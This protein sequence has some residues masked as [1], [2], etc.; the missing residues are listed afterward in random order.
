[1]LVTDEMQEWPGSCLFTCVTYCASRLIVTCSTRSTSSIV[2]G[3][4]FLA[5]LWRALRLP[6]RIE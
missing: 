1:M 5:G 3:N 2:T 6:G 4:L